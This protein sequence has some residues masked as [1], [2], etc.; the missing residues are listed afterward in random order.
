MITDG[1]EVFVCV[2]RSVKGVVLDFWTTEGRCSYCGAYNSKLFF[3]I[4][5]DGYREVNL[6][7]HRMIE[8][9]GYRFNALHFSREDFE[10]IQKLRESGDLIVVRRTI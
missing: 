7:E 5:D 2:N 1:R 3:R 4:Y 8:F 9:G 6:V 10:R